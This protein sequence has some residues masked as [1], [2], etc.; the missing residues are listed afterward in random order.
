METKISLISNKI[1]A[2]NATDKFIKQAKKQRLQFYN[3]NIL[4]LDQLS[5]EQINN[6]NFRSEVINH[7]YNLRKMA[8]LP[9][10][11]KQ[12]I[13]LELHIYAPELNKLHLSKGRFIAVPQKTTIEAALSSIIDKMT[14]KQLV[15]LTK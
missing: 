15:E 5:T 7:A 11:M 4:R 1:N 13:K 14:F 12:V 9:K 3:D 6:Y 2:I 10:I 8:L